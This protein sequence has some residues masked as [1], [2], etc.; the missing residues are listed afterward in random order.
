[1]AQSL[2]RKRSVKDR[3]GWRWRDDPPTT[4]NPLPAPKNRK[5]KRIVWIYPDDQREVKIAAAKAKYTQLAT[6]LDHLAKNCEKAEAEYLK[7]CRYYKT[8]L[9][10][11]YQE[12]KQEL[13]KLK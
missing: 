10:K 3:I 6:E 4:K 9:I 2:Q 1:V 11:K 7:A 13:A 5:G 8:T 12:A